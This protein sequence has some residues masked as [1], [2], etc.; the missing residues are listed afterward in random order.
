MGIV[1]LALLGY[2]IDQTEFLAYLQ[3]L[4]VGLEMTHKLM[5][6]TT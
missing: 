4:C 1:F 6:A 3:L 5:L 2:R